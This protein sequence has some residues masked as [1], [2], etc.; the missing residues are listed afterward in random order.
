M[1]SRITIFGLSLLAILAICPLAVAQQPSAELRAARAAGTYLGSIVYL[2]ELQTTECA[3]V[4]KR[5]FPNVDD[6]IESEILPS[7]G[8]SSRRGIAGAMITLK[9][10]LKQQAKTYINS[11]LSRVRQDKTLDVK[12]G[13]GYVA[14]AIATTHEHARDGWLAAQRDL[15]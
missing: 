2:H 14:G 15:K 13:C 11:L 9:P 12:S 10:E 7:F 5:R 1:A 6:V 8:S 3:Y 4:I